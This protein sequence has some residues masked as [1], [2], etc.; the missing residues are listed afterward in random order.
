M[1]NFFE[2]KKTPLI[3]GAYI[4]QKKIHKALKNKDLDSIIDLF[5]ERS[6]E[7]DIAL[8]REK[9]FTKQDL[10]DSFKEELNDKNFT[11]INW[12]EPKLF[13]YIS[14]GGKTLFIKNA[15]VFNGGG[16]ITYHMYF[17]YENG[18]WIITR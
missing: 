1:D 12:L 15:I 5:V 13:F 8:Y 18:S 7:M 4:L 14:P 9:G 11:L 2:L 10:Y 17:R 6:A 16:S 3:Q